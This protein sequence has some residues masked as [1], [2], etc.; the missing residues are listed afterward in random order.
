MIKL[1]RGNLHAN[2]S[3]ILD[4]Q[5]KVIVNEKNTQR[6]S[7]MVAQIMRGNESMHSY[8]HRLLEMLAGGNLSLVLSL[9]IT[10]QPTL[11][12][13]KCELEGVKILLWGK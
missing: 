7:S 3:F 6:T 1:P 9:L 12:I 5:L 11:V 4:Q 2:G 13:H 8:R 10:I